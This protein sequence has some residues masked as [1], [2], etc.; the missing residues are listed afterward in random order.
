MLAGIVTVLL[1]H[2]ENIEKNTNLVSA[3]NYVAYIRP[4]LSDFSATRSANNIADT[5]QKFLDFKGA[6]ESIGPV[7]IS[8]FL[9]FDSWEKFYSSNLDEAYR[10][11]AV[12]HFSKA[13]QLLP[14]LKPDIDN[15]ISMLNNHEYY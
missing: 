1:T 11:Q 4:W 3:N 6:D 13:S 15:L 8:L 2:P 14:E 5:K 12:E 7:H 9:A 10:E